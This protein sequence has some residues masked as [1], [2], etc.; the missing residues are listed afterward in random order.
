VAEHPEVFDHVGLLINGPPS[1]A[2]LPFSQSSD[3]FGPSF[4]APK[5]TVIIPLETKNAT[6]IIE[7]E[8]VSSDAEQSNSLDESCNELLDADS[9]VSNLNRNRQVGVSRRKPLWES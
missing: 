7:A 9:A 6:G 8:V 3:D 1:M 5:S 2:G 4:P